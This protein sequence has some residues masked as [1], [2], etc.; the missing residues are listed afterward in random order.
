MALLIPSFCERNF[1][2][3]HLNVESNYKYRNLFVDCISNMPFLLRHQISM[4]CSF[5]S[6]IQTQSFPICNF[7]NFV[8]PMDF[9]A[10][11]A[12]LNETAYH[13]LHCFLLFLFAGH[14]D[15]NR[16]I[17]KRRRNSNGMKNVKENFVILQ[18][19]SKLLQSKTI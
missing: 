9:F 3:E 4:H 16:H 11:D 6:S 13:D 5:E 10:E 19:M 1:L 8:N 2:I 15:N 18:T 17:L 7:I 12:D 14:R